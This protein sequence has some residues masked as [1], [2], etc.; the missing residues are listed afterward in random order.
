MKREKRMV[1]NQENMLLQSGLERLFQRERERE[2][3]GT[4][5]ERERA[6]ERKERKEL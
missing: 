1:A 4:K 5:R 2:R 6:T 3:E